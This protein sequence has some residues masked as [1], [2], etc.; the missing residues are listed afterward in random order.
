MPRPRATRS[1]DE[2]RAEATPA[3]VTVSARLTP[4]QRDQLQ[5]RAE[6]AGMEPARYLRMLIL[7][8]IQDGGLAGQQQAAASG[9]DMEQV[10]NSVDLL[11][12]ELARVGRHHQTLRDDT[13]TALRLVLRLLPGIDHRQ[14]D[15]E[16]AKAFPPSE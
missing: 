16:L 15:A 8:D 1:G 10:R 5:A 7:H 9:R 13:V 3:T 4:T 11:R 2:S 6:A 12:A 14:L